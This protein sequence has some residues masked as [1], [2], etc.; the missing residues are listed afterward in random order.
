MRGVL[1]SCLLGVMLAGSTVTDAADAPPP[2]A[3]NAKPDGSLTLKG[4]SVAAGIGFTWGHGELEFG[5]A[6]HR[7]TIRGLS[8]VDVGATEYTAQGHVFNLKNLS[9]FAGNYVA[10]SAGATLGGGVTA[11]WLKNENGVIL[12]LLSTDVGL[13]FNLSADGIRIALKD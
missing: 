4:G 11:T 5:K 3:A 8:V 7:F 6:A 2:V 1:A 13:K 10:L 9:D 12:K